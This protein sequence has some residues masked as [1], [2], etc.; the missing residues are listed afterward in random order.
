MNRQLMTQQQFIGWKYHG[1]L[2]ELKMLHKFPVTILNVQFCLEFNGSG[3]SFRYGNHCSGLIFPDNG[4]LGP[5]SDG[6]DFYP[7]LKLSSSYSQECK[8]NRSTEPNLEAVTKE[9]IDSWNEFAKN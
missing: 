8:F 2:D 4:Y 6:K 7:L 3:V 5:Q 1:W 9:V